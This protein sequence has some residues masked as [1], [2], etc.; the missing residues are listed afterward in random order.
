MKVTEEELAAMK[1]RLDEK[2][3]QQI[4][5]RQIDEVI[6]MVNRHRGS[7]AEKPATNQKQLQQKIEA[8]EHVERVIPA[9]K[10]FTLSSIAVICF[11][12]LCDNW[13]FL[14]TFGMTVFYAVAV[15]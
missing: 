11:R 4:Y 5:E 10:A 14:V 12:S 8:R 3:N 13:L 6:S 1:R 15:C 7:A 2:H 9:A